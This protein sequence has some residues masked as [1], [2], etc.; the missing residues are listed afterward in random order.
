MRELDESDLKREL[1]EEQFDILEEEERNLRR[2]ANLPVN[3]WFVTSNPLLRER[4]E[5]VRRAQRLLYNVELRDLLPSIACEYGEEENKVYITAEGT[6]YY[7]NV[8][9]DQDG[10]PF[11]TVRVYESFNE[12]M[13]AFQ[14]LNLFEYVGGLQL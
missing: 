9:T 4:M 11:T 6:V 3:S 2:E 5:A 1:Q 10:D 7:R 14:L 8:M 13:E 12:F